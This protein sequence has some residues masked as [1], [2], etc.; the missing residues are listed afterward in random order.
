VRVIDVK[1]GEQLS[2]LERIEESG[3]SDDTDEQ[4]SPPDTDSHPEE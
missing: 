2:S 3:E 1:E 4:A